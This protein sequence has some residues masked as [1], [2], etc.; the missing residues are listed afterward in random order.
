MA[1]TRRK[2]TGGATKGWKPKDW[3]KVSELVRVMNMA[4]RDA[5]TKEARLSLISALEKVLEETGNNWGYHKLSTLDDTL[6][7]YY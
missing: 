6:R 4:I 5:E 7:E 2:F 1:T 3:Y